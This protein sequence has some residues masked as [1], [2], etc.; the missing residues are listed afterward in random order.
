MKAR[1]TDEARRLRANIP[2]PKHL[3][4]LRD[5]SGKPLSD[6]EVM[7]I[8]VTVQEAL[9]AM[10]RVANDSFAAGESHGRLMESV[11]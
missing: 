3:Q 1:V 5:V 2:N 6:T 9:D 7:S 11:K 10:R 8:T 4:H